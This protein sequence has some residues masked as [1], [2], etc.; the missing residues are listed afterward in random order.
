MSTSLHAGPSAVPMQVVTLSEHLQNPKLKSREGR[1]FILFK[2]KHKAATRLLVQGGLHGDEKLAQQ[3]VVWLLKRY[4]KGVS[5]LN[6]FSISEV[7]ID[8][9]PFANPD[10]AFHDHRLNKYGVNLNRNFGVLWGESRENPG[11]KSFSE[12][13][14][15]AI[16]SLFAKHKYQS[17]VDVHGYMNW[18]VAP[19]ALKLVGFDRFKQ[20]DKFRMH[21]KWIT[22]LKASMDFLPGYYELKTAGNLGDGGAFED[23]AFWSHNSLAYCL[24]LVSKN[25]YQIRAV[26]SKQGKE[27]GLVDTF[28]MYEKYVYKTFSKAIKLKSDAKKYEISQLKK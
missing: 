10:G 21:D 28:L 25:R 26:D 11:E 9:L 18:I 12:P 1:D 8:F 7:A 15:Q 20:S 22:S 27:S 16:K 2:S 23:W 13:E 24:E 4:S 17:A 5:L 3:F 19:S 14:T 6:R